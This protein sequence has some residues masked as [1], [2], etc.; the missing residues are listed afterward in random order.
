MYCVRV[1]LEQSSNLPLQDENPHS[2]Y[3]L[4]YVEK[5]KFLLI[6]STASVSCDVLTLDA[7]WHQPPLVAHGIVMQKDLGDHLIT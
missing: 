6:K 2:F 4:Y 7:F 1:G 3:Y 5:E